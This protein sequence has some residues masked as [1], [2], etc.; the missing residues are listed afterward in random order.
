MNIPEVKWLVELDVF[1][2]NQ[3]ALLKAIKNAGYNY[4]TLQYI[5][6]D[7]DIVTKTSKLYDENDCV[8]FY[9]SLNFGHKLKKA[10]WV[11]G[12]YLNDKAFECTSYYPIFKE[13]LIHNNY[14]MLPYGDLLNKKYFLFDLFSKSSNNKIQKIFIRPNSGYKQFTGMVCTYDSFEDCVELASFYDVESDLLVLISGVEDLSKEW[15]FVIVDG[16]PISG[17][18]YRDWSKPEKLQYGHT[19]KDYVLMHSHSIAEGCD[20]PN[21]WEKVKQWA[22]MY[23]PDRCWTIDIAKTLSWEYKILE[24]G[25]FSCAGM[26]GNDLN[27]VV[28]AVSESALKEWKEYFIPE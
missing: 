24:I 17:S 13:H 19:T 21:A 22:K 8:V 28:K 14:I 26:Y 3:D 20:D 15:R 5:P 25:C 2:D 12:V 18:L 9:G 16:E 23:N 11:P 7:N 6:F 10:T 27:K 4:K 1:D